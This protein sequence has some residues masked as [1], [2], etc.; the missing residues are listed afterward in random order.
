M[1]D[2][3]KRLTN[4]QASTTLKGPLIHMKKHTKYYIN[5]DLTWG[6]CD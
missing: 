1:F 3:T 6:S 5:E 4:K 2:N